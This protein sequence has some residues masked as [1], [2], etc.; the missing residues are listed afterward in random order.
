MS[1]PKPLDKY[2]VIEK[3][4]E[5]AQLG[6][7]KSNTEYQLGPKDYLLIN[8]TKASDSDDPNSTDEVVQK[9]Y[10]EGTIIRPKLDDGAL[11]DS[12][13]VAAQ[14]SKSYSKKT[15]ILDV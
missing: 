11:I 10:G 6:G 1:T 12:A 3:K 13:T 8:Y 5:N 15:G 2:F 4:G 9:Y 14:N 7:I